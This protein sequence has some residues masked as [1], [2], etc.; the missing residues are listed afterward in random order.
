MANME[1]KIVAGLLGGVA[2]FVTQKL[3]KASWKTITGDEP[4]NPSDPEAST[5]AAVSWAAASAV[6]VAVA[7]VLAQRIVAKRYES[8]GKGLDFDPDNR[9]TI[10]AKV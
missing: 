8:V 3:I 4:P 6:G 9:Q 7:Q 5:V 2:T 1:Y 10:K